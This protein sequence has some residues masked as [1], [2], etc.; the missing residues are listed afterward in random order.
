MPWPVHPPTRADVHHTSAHILS[1]APPSLALSLLVPRVRL[2]DDV[3]VSVVSLAGLSSHHLWYDASPRQ[4]PRS[5]A[6]RRRSGVR[7]TLQCSHLFFT[8]LWTFIPLSCCIQK[9]AWLLGAPVQAHDIQPPAAN[10]PVK[11][12]RLATLAGSDSSRAREAI[13]RRALC[14]AFA[15]QAPLWSM[16]STG[17]VVCLFCAGGLQW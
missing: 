8:E 14:T 3:E 1:P 17:L 7:H 13:A 6:G 4:S 2:A 9:P 11:G 5:T 15:M 16:P 12:R 10:V